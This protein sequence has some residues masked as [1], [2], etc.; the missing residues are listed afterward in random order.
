[1]KFAI[2]LYGLFR[3][4]KTVLFWTEMFPAGDIFI[5]S[6]F[7]STPNTIRSSDVP[8]MANYTFNGILQA[9]YWSIVDQDEYDIAIDLKSLVHNRKDPW[10]TLNKASLSNAV[11]VLYIIKSLKNLFIAHDDNYTHIIL[12]RVDLMFTRKINYKVFEH[13]LVV[14]NYGSFGDANDR[15]VAGPKHMVLPLLDRINVWKNTSHLSE[16][17]VKYCFKVYNLKVFTTNIGYN[18]RIRANGTIHKP[19]YSTNRKC[20][21]D[22]INNIKDIKFNYINNCKNL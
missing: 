8:I 11:R 12:T 4:P 18:R 17:L 3:T 1:M 19:Q 2:L 13:R 10:N 21:L 16:K 20:K 6:T 22:F 5:F 15:F 7:T 9:K 14:P